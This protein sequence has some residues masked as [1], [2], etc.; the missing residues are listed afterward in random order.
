MFLDFPESLRPCWD[1]RPETFRLSPDSYKR[2]RGS[3]LGLSLLRRQTCSSLGAGLTN[4]CT[5]EPAK[6]S[7]LRFV[8]N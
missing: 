4:L 7:H 5:E 3:P 2:E 1:E 6:A 8:V